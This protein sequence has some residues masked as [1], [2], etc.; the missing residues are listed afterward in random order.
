MIFSDL[1]VT[2]SKS[3]TAVQAEKMAKYMQNRFRFWGIAKPELTAIIKPYIAA[4]KRDAIDWDAIFCLWDIE[5]REAQYVAL[6]Y[7]K[8]HKKQ[9]QTSDFDNIKKLIVTKSWWDTVDSLDE[10]VGLLVQQNAKLA[11]TVLT[12]SLAD[13]ILLRRVSIDYQLKF[14]EKT[15]TSLLSEA[16]RNNFG[17]DDFFI[18]KAIGWSLREYSK[19]DAK[20]VNDFVCGYR[21]KLNKLSVKEAVKYL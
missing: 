20:W 8:A 11:D 4:T 1:V 3:G 16:I 5:Y 12:W 21:D 14:K 9:L 13:N 2:L 19:T 15:D 17:S 10:F 6:E 7:L 18:N